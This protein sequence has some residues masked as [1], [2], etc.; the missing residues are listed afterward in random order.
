MTPPLTI[1]IPG[2]FDRSLATNTMKGRG[3][4]ANYKHKEDLRERTNLACSQVLATH[5]LG[6]VIM[7]WKTPFVVD[8]AVYYERHNADM[9]LRRTFDDDNVAPALK[10]AR[11]VIASWLGVSDRNFRTGQVEQVLWSSHKLSLIHI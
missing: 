1:I 11:D 9:T 2:T 3:W 5:Y 10:V 4:Q 6:S 7:G 8:W